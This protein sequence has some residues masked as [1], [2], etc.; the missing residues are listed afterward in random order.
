MEKSLFIRKIKEKM[1]N[2]FKKKHSKVFIAHDSL[3]V[4]IF[5]RRIEELFASRIHDFHFIN[6]NDSHF[7]IIVGKALT[8]L[9]IAGCSLRDALEGE[10]NSFPEEYGKIIGMLKSID[11]ARAELANKI[12]I[13]PPEIFFVS[14]KENRLLSIGNIATEILGFIKSEVA[15]NSVTT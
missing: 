11:N 5:L 1:T 6:P 4:Y 9:Y 14:F 15:K 10:S 8:E 2:E 13:N 12:G 3:S 7:T